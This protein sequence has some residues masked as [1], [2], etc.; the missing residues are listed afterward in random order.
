M[1][2]LTYSTSIYSGLVL[3]RMLDHDIFAMGKTA[4]LR[5]C[6]CYKNCC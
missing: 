5:S 2:L 3:L 1:S 4:A 6:V